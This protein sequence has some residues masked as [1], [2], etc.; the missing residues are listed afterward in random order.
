MA[1]VTK[2]QTKNKGTVYDVQFYLSR[3]EKKTVYGFTN[4]RQA[5]IFGGRLDDLVTMKG[6]GLTDRDLLN[7]VEKLAKNSPER[8]KTLVKFGLAEPVTKAGN[9]AELLARYTSDGALKERTIK[10]RVTVGNKLMAYFG[11][12]KPIDSFT[13]SE[14]LDYYEYLKKTLSPA[15]WKRDVGKVK[16]IFKIAVQ[17]GWIK[18]NPF[19][20]IKGGL[21]DNPGRFHF[22][23]IDEVNRILAECTDLETRL[24][25]TL[26]RFGGLRIPSEIEFMEWQDFNIAE[27]F[28][29]VKIPKKTNKHNQEI[30]NFTTRI[31]PLFPEIREAFTEY[32]ESFPDGAPSLLF[33]KHPT[34]QALKSRFNKILRRAGVEV[35]EKFFQNMR[36]TRETELLDRWP[37]QEV[38]AW[39]GNTPT[40][41]RRHYLQTRPEN[42][43]AAAELMT[44]KTGEQSEKKSSIKSSTLTGIN[45]GMT[46]IDR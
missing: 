37:I 44:L 45:S 8:Y 32:F 39:I 2:R 12:N 14:A 24:I 15:T 21:S 28:F 22:V 26:A 46:G 10:G 41:A 18:E 35:W 6:H 34:G 43:K 3:N 17:L 40:V 25:F 29:Y 11:E 27:G 20:D 13:A 38:T 36:S 5:E 1:S 31:V 16:Q 9:L 7:W 33:P 19:K 30:G 42:L 4:K 23:T